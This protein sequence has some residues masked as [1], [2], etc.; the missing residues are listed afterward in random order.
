M[1][2]PCI[3]A[4]GLAGTSLPR[5][6]APRPHRRHWTPQSKRLYPFL[7]EF[8]VTV[9]KGAVEAFVVSRCVLMQSPVVDVHAVRAGPIVELHLLCRR[10]VGFQLAS[11][12][13]PITPAVDRADRPRGL[14]RVGIATPVDPDPATAAATCTSADNPGAGAA[15][16]GTNVYLLVLRIRQ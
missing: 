8:N 3:L 5:G 13:L 12:R 1:S 15:P 11:S 14:I 7:Q 16:G 9:E 6:V 10:L 4:L 2:L